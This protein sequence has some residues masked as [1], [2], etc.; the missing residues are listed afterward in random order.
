[1]IVLLLLAGAV[2][3][4]L[5]GEIMESLDEG[6]IWIFMIIAVVVFLLILA[7]NG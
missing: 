5:I 3:V 6:S 4:W 1:M 2:G 7:S